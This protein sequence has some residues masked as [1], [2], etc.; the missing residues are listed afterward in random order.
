VPLFTF[1]YSLSQ[2]IVKSHVSNYLNIKKINTKF[3]CNSFQ[4]ISKTFHSVGIFKRFND[5]AFCAPRRAYTVTPTQYVVLNTHTF[6]FNKLYL[7]TL[8]TLCSY[9]L[10]PH[11]L[12]PN[13][14][15]PTHS[16]IRIPQLFAEIVTPVHP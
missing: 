8:Y 13:Q 7:V 2:K 6:Y 1:T 16:I 11:T 10:K 12:V 14:P 5:S 9:F 15:Q 3:T 4:F